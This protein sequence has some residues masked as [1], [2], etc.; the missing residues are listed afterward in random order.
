MFKI[1]FKNGDTMEVTQVN[2]NSLVESMESLDANN[3]LAFQ[4][5]NDGDDTKTIINIKEIVKV[6]EVKS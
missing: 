4:A 1:S 3:N 6:E 5:F 2:I